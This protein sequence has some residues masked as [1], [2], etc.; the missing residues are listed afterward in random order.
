MYSQFMDGAFFPLGQ[1]DHTKQEN[2]YRKQ[3]T[4]TAAPQ[5]SSML[6]EVTGGLSQLLGGLLNNF[7]FKG[8]DTGDILLV[9]IVLFLFLEGDNLELV[10]TLG[11][12]F[13]LG[14]NDDQAPS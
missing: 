4:K 12:L 8:F 6:G 1:T 13:L 5:K 7:S 11:L 3:Q 14:L 2:S 9:L 10:I